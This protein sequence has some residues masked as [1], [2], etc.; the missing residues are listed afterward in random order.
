LVSNSVGRSTGSGVGISA[1]RVVNSTGIS[2][3]GT[4][5]SSTNGYNCVG[6]STSGVGLSGTFTNSTGIST[7]GYAGSGGTKTNC[8]LISSS[9]YGSFQENLNNTFLQSTT[10]VPL[11]LSTDKL[12]NSCTA[13]CLWNNAGGHAINTTAA[14]T[15]VDIRNC[16]LS[17]TNASA[18]CINGA[19][20]STFKYASNTFKGSTTAVNST[21]ITQGITNLSDTKGNILI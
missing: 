11:W 14:A 4:A 12:V 18:Y 16:N 2:S 10:N 15:G 7:S 3:S 13:I 5:I 21:N 1:P 17:V 8:T 9:N 19:S 20:G 6:I